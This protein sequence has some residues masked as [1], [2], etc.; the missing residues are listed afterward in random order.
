MKHRLCS[1]I[2]DD[3]PQGHAAWDW[4]RILHGNAVIRCDC[5]ELGILPDKIA[6]YLYEFPA[7]LSVDLVVLNR[8]ANFWE[9]LCKTDSKPVFA[10]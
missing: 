6:C 2:R 8:T 9:P 1:R 7:N 10:K 4:D 5:K 3:Q